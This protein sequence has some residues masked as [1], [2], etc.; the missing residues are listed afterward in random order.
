M[1]KTLHRFRDFARKRWPA[2]VGLIAA[3]QTVVA[4]GD[5]WPPALRA[6]QNSG[7]ACS[8]DRRAA[9]P[10]RQSAD[11]CAPLVSARD[12]GICVYRK[13]TCPPIAGE[14]DHNLRFASSRAPRI[15]D[16]RH[17][18]HRH[19]QFDLYQPLQPRR[20]TRNRAA[21]VAWPRNC[22]TGVMS[23]SS[24]RGSHRR[25]RTMAIRGL[26]G[27]G[28]VPRCDHPSL[29]GGIE[30]ALLGLGPERHDANGTTASPLPRTLDSTASQL[31]PSNP[32]AA[33][34]RFARCA[35]QLAR[36]ACSGCQSDAT[37]TFVRSYAARYG[38]RTTKRWSA[39]P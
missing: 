19:E 11:G 17:A 30:V 5:P 8:S 18:E 21:C 12:R 13:P 3:A 16:V 6:A 35:S 26:P 1:L 39:T 22:V 37:R 33:K 25:R 24:T 31:H 34:S 29:R 7:L 38:S 23:R 36:R 15:P 10:S 28:G 2:S 9:D 27:P 14:R 32:A 20:R 4:S